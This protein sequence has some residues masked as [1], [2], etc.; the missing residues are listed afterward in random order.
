MTNDGK[1]YEFA[2]TVMDRY[3]RDRIGTADEVIIT[4]LSGNVKPMIWQGTPIQLR[5]DF[6]DADAFK[7]FLTK[8]ADTSGS[9]IMDGISDT[10]EYVLEQPG[11]LK[12]KKK[13]CLLALTD[14]EDNINTVKSLPRF[15]RDLKL[16]AEAKAACGFYWVTQTLV[17]DLKVNLTDA[18]FTHYVVEPE[19]KTNPTLPTFED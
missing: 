5:A 8:K 11:V 1:A 13:V 19:F 14:M 4:Q 7:A 18:G 2:L 16:L 15:K 6:D 3:F 17:H 9:R 12:G 10:I